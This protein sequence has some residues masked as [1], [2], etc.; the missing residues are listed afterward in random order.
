MLH[1][2][3]SM[4]AFALAASISPGPVNLVALRSGTQYGFR[5]SLPHV[6]GATIG[7]TVLLLLTG[8]GLHVLL[9]ALPILTRVIQD[10]GVVFLLYLAYKLAL[11]DGQLHL[12]A[13][14]QS[15]SAWYGALMQW[16]NPKAWLASIAGMGAYAAHGES[17]L[18]WQFALIY[19]FICFG[20]I[21]AWAYAGTALRRFL[22]TPGVM[23]TFNRVLAALLAFSALVLLLS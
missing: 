10:A 13:T 14:R 11:D 1:I 12:D 7:F 22:K 23:R 15:P 6:S 9:E 2:Y 20:S 17:A 8:L 18:I 16:I 21:A 4:A 5:A 19:F 3:F